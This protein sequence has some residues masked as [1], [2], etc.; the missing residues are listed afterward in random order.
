MRKRRYG[1]LI[2][3]GLLIVIGLLLLIDNLD[4]L[5]DWDAPIWSLILGACGLVFLAIY[6]NDRAQWW[7]LIPGLVILG[8]AAA[9]FLAE[10]DLVEGYVVATIIL[11]A[12]GLPFLLIF[13]SDRQHWWAL[14]PAYVL[15]VVAVSRQSRDCG[16]FRSEAP[17][18][19]GH[20]PNKSPER[21]HQQPSTTPPGSSTMN[22]ILQH[23]K[24]MT[25]YR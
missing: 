1:S 22:L 14:I 11:A 10:Q 25:Q 5:G 17:Q 3:G 20:G 23:R 2:W 12:V 16:A 15:L 8:I 21:N 24:R 9:V 7:A 19:P 18:C 4:L 13:V 6:A